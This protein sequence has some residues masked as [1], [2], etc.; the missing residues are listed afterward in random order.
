M[1]NN[2]SKDAVYHALREEIDKMPVGMPKTKS[3]VEIKILKHLFTAEEAKIALNLNIVPEPIEKI[4]TRVK[5]KNKQISFEELENILD[6]LGEKGAITF[7]EHPREGKKFYS[8]AFFAVGMFE[9]QVNKMTK[10]FY[11]DSVEYLRSGFAQEF[12]RTGVPQ[13]RVVPVNKAVS[14]EHELPIT[15]YENMRKFIQEIHDGQFAVM[16]CICKQG[17][18]MIEEPCKTTDVRETCIIFPRASS[19]FVN[20]GSAREISKEETLEILQRAEDESLVIQPGNTQKPSFICCCCGDCCGVLSLAKTFPKPA[21]VFA[22]N[23]F[24]VVDTELCK[25]CGTCVKRCQMDALS[26]VNKKVVID[27]NHCI[28]CGLCVVK[29]PTGAIQLKKKEKEIFPPKSNMALYQ[30][31]MSKKYGKIGLLKAGAKIKL[32]MKV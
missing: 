30:S 5:K 20:N 14:Q 24:A 32:G 7:F 3:G 10:E 27:L 4:Y 22:T 29:C 6:N 8:Y 17:K 26:I 28:G 18:D 2:L 15:T 13:L 31:I 12:A 11:E 16:N 23:Y 1:W 21:E 19:Y 25:G 9:Y